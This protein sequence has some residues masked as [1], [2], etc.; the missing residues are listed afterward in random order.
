MP[1]SYP[2]PM[3]SGLLE[4][5]HYKRIGSAIWLFL[6]CVSS[7]TKD[8]EKDGVTW[9][10]V[11]GNKPIKRE[12][13]AA[14]FGVAERTVQRWIDTLESEEYI[15]ITRAPYGMIFT[16]RNS[17]KFNGR[18]D[19]NV[20][21]PP[22]RLDKN[23]QSDRTEWTEMSSHR[24]KNVHSN[25]DIIKILIDRWINGLLED[26]QKELSSRSGVLTS[27]VGAV[28]T[29]QIDLDRPTTEQKALQIEQY[30]MSRKEVLNPVA[31]DW[32]HLCEVANE[33][34]PLDLVYFFIDLAFARKKATRK[35]LSD[36]IRLFSYCKT[37]ILNC[38]DELKD[39]LENYHASSDAEK[40]KT[41]KNTRSKQEKQFDV[42]DQFI[43]EEK[44]RGQ[45]GN[46]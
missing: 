26:D 14:Q 28:S 30:Y 41:G 20:H 6:W 35:R 17:K 19:K 37:V 10:I 18:L 39:F 15:K 24:D 34:I 25:K 5:E 45:G 12:E 23:V 38:W 42:L 4:P 27:A 2:F 29:G 46:C 32:K 33:D 3:Y 31:A 11:L 13:L 44:E 9:G 7:T 21:S 22:E 16:V 1:E 8:I 36:Q 40:N 43:R